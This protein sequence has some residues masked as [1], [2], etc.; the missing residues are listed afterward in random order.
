MFD[1]Y[2][3]DDKYGA[4]EDLMDEEDFDSE[5]AMFLDNNILGREGEYD[6][7]YWRK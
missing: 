2:Y 6:S 4:D 7:L 1:M 3:Y 5:D